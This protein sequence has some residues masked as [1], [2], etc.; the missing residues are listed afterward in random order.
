MLTVQNL[1]FFPKYISE[2]ISRVRK[3]GIIDFL[4]VGLKFTALVVSS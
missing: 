2:V 4:L 1:S 3:V